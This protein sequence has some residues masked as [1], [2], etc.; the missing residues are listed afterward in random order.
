MES[1]STQHTTSKD[2]TAVLLEEMRG[3]IKLIAE[4]QISL[5]QELGEF[6]NEMYIFRDEM[7]AFKD[8]MYVFRNEMYNFKD[9]TQGNFRFVAKQLLSIDN[10]LQEIKE[11]LN[12]KADKKW[13]IGLLNNK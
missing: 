13:V 2:Y 6:K 3:D 7:Y 12:Q 4:G 5:R 10:E 11:N 9:E 8:E 1:Q